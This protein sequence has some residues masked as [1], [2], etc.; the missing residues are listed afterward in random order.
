L[1]EPSGHDVFI[2]IGRRQVDVIQ[3][4]VERFFGRFEEFAARLESDF[5]QIHAKAYSG[6]VGS[7][8]AYQGYHVC[9]DCFFPDAS[10]QDSDNVAINICVMH[11]TTEP[12]LCEASVGS[13][14]PNAYSELD[15]LEE[16]VPLSAEAIAAIEAGLPKLFEALRI[17]VARRSPPE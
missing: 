1:V 2:G 9:L 15:L 10:P 3:T 13:G 7:L 11:L 4:L 6:P 5:A 17:A 12:M 16:P 8:T 14:A